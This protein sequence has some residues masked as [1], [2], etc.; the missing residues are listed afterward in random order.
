MHMKPP[1]GSQIQ[2]GHPLAQGLVGAWL[3]NEGGGSCVNDLSG[4]PNTGTIIGATWVGG[5]FGSCLIFDGSSTYVSMGNG[6]GVFSAQNMTISVWALSHTATPADY[7]KVIFHYNSGNRIY[8]QYGTSSTP[9]MTWQVGDSV[10]SYAVNLEE[11]VWKNYVMVLRAGTDLS[12]Y[13]NGSYVSSVT[14]AGPTAFSNWHLG[15]NDL[16]ESSYWDGLIDDV[17]IYHRALPAAE[18]Q[19]LYVRPFGIFQRRPIELWTGAKA[20]AVYTGTG[21]GTAT[22]ATASAS[23]TYAVPVYTASGSPSVVKASA[24]A[25]ATYTV[26]VYTATGSPVV[27]QASASASATYTVPVYSGTGSPSITKATGTASGTFTVPVYTASGGATI[28]QPTASAEGTFLASTFIAAV[29]SFLLLKRR[30]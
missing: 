10:L 19:E 6:S 12:I 22:K 27:T 13:L 29:T 17:R 7:A 20:A 28:R 9:Q 2:A 25:S 3:M 8:L 14:I 4:N 5:K 16:G 1:L 11:M 18:V 23:A 24:S 30:H 21:G 26:P 15:R